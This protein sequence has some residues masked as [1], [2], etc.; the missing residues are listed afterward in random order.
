MDGYGSI[1]RKLW[2]PYG[3]QNSGEEKKNGSITRAMLG[4][5]QGGETWPH[6]PHRTRTLRAG[7]RKMAVVAVWDSESC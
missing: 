3:G 6:D 1:G 4:F 2:V 7:R 5:Q